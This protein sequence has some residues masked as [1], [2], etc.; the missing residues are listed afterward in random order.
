MNLEQG[1]GNQVIDLFGFLRRRGKFV[2]IVSGAFILL[3]FWITMALPNLYTSSAMILVEPQSVDEDLVN[4]GVRESDLNERLG[5]MTAEILS[6]IRLSKIIDDMNLYEEESKDLQRIEVVDLMRSYISVVPVLSELEEGQRR[7]D[8]Q[9]NTFRII[10]QHEDA[11]VAA[12]VAQQIANDFINANIEARTDVTKKSLEFMEDEIE[13]LTS[14]LAEVEGKISKVKAEAAGR[15]PEDFESNQR[16]LQFAMGDLRDAQR[17]LSSAQSDAAYWKNQ[18]LTAASMMGG[19]DPTSPANRKR[20]LE[21][22]R[23]TML[24]RGYTARHPDVVRVEA[25]IALLTDQLAASAAS[26]GESAPQSMGEQN[27]RAEQGRAELRA[28]AAE[29]DIERLREQI[30]DLEARLA[31]TPVVA[32]RLDGLN[33]QYEGLYRSYQDFSNR[34]QQASVQADLERRQLGEKFL[35][36]ESAEPAPEPSS[37]NRILILVLGAILGLGIAAGA[38]LVAEVSDSSVHTTSELQQSLGIPVLVSVP[39]IMLESDRAA[40][41]RRILRE[42]L[43]AIAVVLFVLIGGGVTYY[44]VNMAGKS[45]GED[46]PVE[47]TIEEARAPFGGIGLG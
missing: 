1:N 45:Q 17:I 20:L 24:A 19:G 4:S 2:A 47:A 15:L 39:R 6:R 14:E 10:F 18:V 27:A 28:V 31:E 23:G 22:E 29:E 25:E 33:R 3:T 36:L 11:R 34:L 32:E 37:P 35:I 21:I 5:L 16:M 12:A 46:A 13:S 8:V 26:A 38:G 44:F 40:R 9:F 42:T 41:S 7:R 43:A 30:A